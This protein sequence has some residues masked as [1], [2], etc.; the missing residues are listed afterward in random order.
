MK[1]YVARKTNFA[2]KVSDP[3]ISNLKEIPPANSEIQ[4]AK[5]SYSFLLLNLLH[6]HTAK[7][8]IKQKRGLKPS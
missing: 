3:H 7:S 2:D 4:V 5:V 8:A 1:T 6:S